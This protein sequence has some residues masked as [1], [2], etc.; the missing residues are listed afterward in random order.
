M[1]RTI[2]IVSTFLCSVLLVAQEAGTQLRSELEELHA[3]W[4]KAFDT[5]DGATMDQ[6]EVDN[7]VL[8]MPNGDIWRKPGP[9]A[10]KQR[11]LDPQS[12]RTLTNVVVRRFGDSSVLTGV[13]A[14]KLNNQSSRDAETVV[15]VQSS[16]R[17]KIASVQWTSTTSA[18]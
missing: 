4:F 11:K 17:W 6:M 9:R 2:I 18:K 1:R 7:L 14:T 3:K 15:F 16:G 12:E 5:G 8:V 13:L 10:G